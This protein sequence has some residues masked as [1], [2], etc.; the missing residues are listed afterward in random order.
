MISS[1]TTIS[2]DTFPRWAVWCNRA[3][4]SIGFF[5]VGWAVLLV[6]TGVGLSDPVLAVVDYFHPGVD[7]PDNWALALAYCFRVLAFLIATSLMLLMAGSSIGWLRLAA[8]FFGR[9]RTP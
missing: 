1:L 2:D 8:G 3:A 5:T 9:G 7:A 6:F 4:I